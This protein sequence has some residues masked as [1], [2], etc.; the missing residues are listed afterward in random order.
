ML[1]L[2]AA[3]ISVDNFRNEKNE[4]KENSLYNIKEKPQLPIT[5][6]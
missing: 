1:E 5:A 4:L 2:I 6:I 3:L